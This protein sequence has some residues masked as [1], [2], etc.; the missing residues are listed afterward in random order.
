MEKRTS[1][2]IQLITNSTSIIGVVSLFYVVISI[3]LENASLI[4]EMTIDRYT[5]YR[6]WMKG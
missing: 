5:R 4:V 3:V 1:S 6:K 2:V